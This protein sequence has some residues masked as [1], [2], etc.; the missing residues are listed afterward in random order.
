MGSS[1]GKGQSQAAEGVRLVSMN[2]RTGYRAGLVT[3]TA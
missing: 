3:G 2:G 1:Q